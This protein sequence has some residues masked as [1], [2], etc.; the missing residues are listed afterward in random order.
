MALETWKGSVWV[1]VATGMSPM[2]VVTGA[3]RDAT[4]TAS[5]LPASHRGSISGT[6]APLRGERVVEGHEV[7]Q[8][9]FGGDGEVGPVAAAGDGLGVGRLP[10]RLGMPAVAVECDA[11]DAGDHSSGASVFRNAT[12]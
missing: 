2:C 1:T 7:Q 5:G 4:S 3:T 8:P 11:P 9:T 10:P 6:A 12:G